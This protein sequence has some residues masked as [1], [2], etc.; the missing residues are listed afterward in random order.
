MNRPVKIG[1]FLLVALAQLYVPASMIWQYEDTLENGTLFKFKCAPV[2]PY[3][4][5]RGRYVSLRFPQ[6]DDTVRF[7]W[8][9]A[10]DFG[11]VFI[12]VKQGENDFAEIMDISRTQ[13]DS[14][15]YFRA[16]V[17]YG[18]LEYPFNRFYMDE[19]AAPQA[20]IAYTETLRDNLLDTYVTV[21]ILN[22]Q[23]V[24]EELYLND[25]PVGEYLR[26]H[27]E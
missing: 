24:L 10:M 3:D 6:Q 7:K 22:G 25:M 20:E 16:I 17:R 1:I 18:S 19:F 27:P 5:F 8:L 26:T 23:A 21:R 12:S 4:P 13:P 9:P 14:A 15:N 11:S 2:D